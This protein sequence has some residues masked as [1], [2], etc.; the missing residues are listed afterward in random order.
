MATLVDLGLALQ[1]VGVGGFLSGERTPATSSH[2]SEPRFQS[3]GL[4]KPAPSSTKPSI[5]RQV[6]GQANSAT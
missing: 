6:E 5:G 3:L 1:G 2:L 4:R